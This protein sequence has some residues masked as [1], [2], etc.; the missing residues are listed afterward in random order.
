MKDVGKRIAERMRSSATAKMI[1]VAVLVLLFLIPMSMIGGVIRERETTRAYA[2]SDIIGIWGGDQTL[3]GPILHVPCLLRRKDAEGKIE[4]FRE[5]A[6]FL[7]EELDVKGE[8]VPEKRSRGI[9]DVTIYTAE[10]HVS[11]RFSV[12]DFGDWRIPSQDILWEDAYLSVEFP[13]MRSLSETVTLSWENRSIPFEA[14]R[15]TVGMY[16]GEIWAPVPLARDRGARTVRNDTG[17]TFFSFKLK[18]NGG[19]SLS[20]IPLGRETRVAMSSPWTSPSF[21]GAFLPAS[22]RLDADGFRAEWYVLSLGRSFPQ[23]WRGVEID[24]SS[25]SWS[26]FGVNLMIPVDTYAKA[27]RSVKY[28]L[29]FVFLPFITFFLFEVFSGIR[30]HPV[31]YMLVG[32]AVSL[33]YLL[34]LSVAEHLPFGWTYLLASTATVALI[35]VYSSAVLTTCRR[36]AV[37]APILAAAYIFLYVLLQSEDYAL[38]IGS[39]GLFSVLAAVMIATRKVDW[40]SLG[41]GEAGRGAADRE[42]SANAPREREA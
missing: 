10:L 18:L 9:Y 19:R 40:Y 14:G 29:L 30:V 36:G 27:M 5:L 16:E 34:L 2:E 23:K 38:L 25:I 24:P 15:A 21:S 39:I 37:V 17:G 20:F 35:T 26:A 28:G 6:H 41:R 4:V 12:P 32:F 42:R 33:F 11:G 8:V 31:Q 22:R 7:P 13:D 1:F 3:G